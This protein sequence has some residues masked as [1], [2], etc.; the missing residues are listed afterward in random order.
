MQCVDGSFP[1]FFVNDNCDF[2]KCGGDAVI[3]DYFQDTNLVRKGRMDML[4]LK[5]YEEIKRIMNLGYQYAQKQ[6][7]DGKF[8]V[9]DT[10]A[11]MLL[12]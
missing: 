3:F 2:L 5:A 12:N 10:D 7:E 6:H 4:E 9:F 8:A 11:V 1:D